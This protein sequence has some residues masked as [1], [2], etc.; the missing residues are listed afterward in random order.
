MSP[1]IH[2]ICVK[3]VAVNGVKI[4]DDLMQDAT[5]FAQITCVLALKKDRSI[6]SKSSLPLRTSRDN[7]SCSARW[8]DERDTDMET[9]SVCFDTKMHKSTPKDFEFSVYLRRGMEEIEIG[10]T[11]LTFRGVLLKAELDIPINQVLLN[12]IQGANKSRKVR[13]IFGSRSRMKKATSFENIEK[14]SLNEKSGLPCFR[15]GDGGRSYTL[16]EVATIRVI[17]SYHYF[18]LPITSCKFHRKSVSS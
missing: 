8:Y 9:S 13:G 2:T 18:S 12:D 1:T 7:A 6:M 17:V 3:P 5:H 10:S 16:V 15:G 14:L 11:S 4:L